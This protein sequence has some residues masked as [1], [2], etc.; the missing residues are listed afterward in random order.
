[1]SRAAVAVEVRVTT[2]SGERLKLSNDELTVTDEVPATT[3]PANLPG[4]GGAA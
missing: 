4:D 1:M 2:E 3:E